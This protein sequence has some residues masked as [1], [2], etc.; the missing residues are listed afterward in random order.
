MLGMWAA[1]MDQ[2]SAFA[3]ATAD[4]SRPWGEMASVASASGRFSGLKQIQKNLSKD[5]MLR[6]IDQIWNANPLREVVPIDW[7][8][9]V[10]V[11]RV[12]G[13][14]DVGEVAIGMCG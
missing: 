10:S 7:A 6:S 4:H 13:E 1:W 12:G 3:P 9:I 8:E 14:S 5:S 2:L 11:H